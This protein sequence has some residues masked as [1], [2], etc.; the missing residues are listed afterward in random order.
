MATRTV[1]LSFKHYYTGAVDSCEDLRTYVVDRRTR[2][3]SCYRTH[4]SS[5]VYIVF[6]SQ[7]TVCS[8]QIS[9][10]ERVNIVVYLYLEVRGLILL[11]TCI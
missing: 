5:F 7:T 6:S 11:S 1:S 3:L 8:L 4:L 2:D 9:G 10:G